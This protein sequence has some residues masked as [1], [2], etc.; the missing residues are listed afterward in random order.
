MSIGDYAEA[1]FYVVG[2]HVSRISEEETPKANA[3]PFAIRT[4][5]A[6]LRKQAHNENDEQ[7]TGIDERYD[8][9]TFDL[10]PEEQIGLGT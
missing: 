9:L 10:D 4:L 3:F 1:G 7:A 5:R 2:G 6:S 8:C